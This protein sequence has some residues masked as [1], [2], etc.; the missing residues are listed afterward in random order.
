[1]DDPA[2]LETLTTYWQEADK[3]GVIG[4]PT[5]VIGDQVFWGNDRIDFVRDHLYDLGLRR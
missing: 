1:M 4:V 5:L 2:Y 3:L